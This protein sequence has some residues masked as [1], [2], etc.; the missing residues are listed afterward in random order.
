[1]SSDDLEKMDQH[2]KFCAL[3]VAF[4]SV[5]LNSEIYIYLLVFKYTLLITVLL[6][7]RLTVVPINILSLEH[8]QVLGC[9]IKHY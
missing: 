1:M 2:K 5:Q 3:L 8:L 9:K 7:V 4:V 6:F